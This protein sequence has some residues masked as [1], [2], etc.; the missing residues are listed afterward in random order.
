MIPAV[1]AT[2]PAFLVHLHSLVGVLKFDYSCSY[3]LLVILRSVMRAL[4]Q[5]N[6]NK[7]TCFG[8]CVRNAHLIMNECFI[9]YYL[10]FSFMD[11]P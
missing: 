3:P 5:K 4:M 1:N 6:N 10:I 8:E 2:A 7:D 11:I 9:H